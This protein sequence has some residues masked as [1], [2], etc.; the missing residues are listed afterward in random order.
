MGVSA[1]WFQFGHLS[2][3][4]KTTRTLTSAT[5]SVPVSQG[6]KNV[7]E[8]VHRDSF[9][10]PWVVLLSVHILLW[11]CPNEQV[12]TL[13]CPPGAEDRSKEGSSFMAR[14]ACGRSSWAPICVE[15][16]GGGGLSGMTG[17]GPCLSPSL[18]L[19][20]QP[21]AGHS[22]PSFLFEFLIP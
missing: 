15:T 22:H 7:P 2:S 5:A 21:P 4:C 19:S 9:V 11:V 1:S 20:L 18:T 10:L 12:L 8:H 14:G 17:A 3:L 6:L 16:A 13:S